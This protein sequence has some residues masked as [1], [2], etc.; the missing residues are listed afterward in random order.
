MLNLPLMQLRKQAPGSLTLMKM[1]ECF[2]RRRFPRT[3]FTIGDFERGKYTN[4]PERFF[5]VYA[6]CVQQPRAAIEAAYRKTRRM[7][8]NKSGPFRKESVT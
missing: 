4:P 8:E 5:E 6:E 3:H 7:R 1:S 2:R